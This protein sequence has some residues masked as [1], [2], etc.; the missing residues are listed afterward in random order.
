MKNLFRLI[1]KFAKDNSVFHENEIQVNVFGELR[2]F[3]ASTKKAL[4]DLVKETTN[5]KKLVLN[6]GVGYGGRAEIV[7]AANEFVKKGKRANEKTFRQA[8]YSKNQ[9]D[10]DLLIRTGGKQRIS[11][12]LIWQLAYAELY[13]TE[14]MWPEFDKTELKKALEWFCKQKRTFGK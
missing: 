7:R 11:N 2:G 6:L 14:K 1:E 4:T 13:F 5:H 9:P 12:F 10:P 8:L 3:P